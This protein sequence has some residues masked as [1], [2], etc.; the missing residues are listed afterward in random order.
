MYYRSS[1]FVGLCFVNQCLTF[2]FKFLFVLHL[3]DRGGATCTAL[4][5]KVDF[6]LIMFIMFV[7]QKRLSLIL[8]T[9]LL[10]EYNVTSVAASKLV[11]LMMLIIVNSKTLTCE[12]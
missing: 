9:F 11:C 3:F 8:K 6:F 2:L 12:Y 1:L 5:T 4:L 7:S 10:I